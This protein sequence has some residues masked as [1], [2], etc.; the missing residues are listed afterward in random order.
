MTKITFE[1]RNPK[2][3]HRVGNFYRDDS[4]FIFLLVRLNGDNNEEAEVA[5]LSFS[6]HSIPSTK[7][8]VKNPNDI[9]DKEFEGICGNISRY[10]HDF[11]YIQQV[12]IDIFQ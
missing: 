9:T 12:K 4:G 3:T 2:V 10:A 5:I 8:T 11:T 7:V 1:K 6:S